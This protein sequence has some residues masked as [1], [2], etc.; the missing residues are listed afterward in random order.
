M[1]LWILDASA[2]LALIQEEPG[3]EIVARSIVD[4][5]V[6]STVNIVEVM[7]KLQEDGKPRDIARQMIDS[8]EVQVVELSLE[9]AFTAGALHATYRRN[10]LSLADCVCLALAQSL[11]GTA[12]T[13]DRAWGTLDADLPVRLIR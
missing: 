6:V 13:A 7:S 12:L 9:D 5:A 4:G 3:E 2:I 8:L 11:E 1:T 10:G